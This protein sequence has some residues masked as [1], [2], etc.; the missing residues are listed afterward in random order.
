[1]AQSDFSDD[2]FEDAFMSSEAAK[3]IGIQPCEKNTIK[4][5]EDFGFSFRPYE[6]QQCFMQEMY[7]VL[8]NG[9]IGIFESPTGTGKSLSL[10]CASISWLKN[11]EAMHLAEMQRLTENNSSKTDTSNW[12]EEFEQEKELKQLRF[13]AEAELKKRQELGERLKHA[14]ESLMGKQ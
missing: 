7:K 3:S 4:V 12:L 8:E 6:I 9:R 5:L 13:E 1:M 14:N 2:D 10:L 11:F